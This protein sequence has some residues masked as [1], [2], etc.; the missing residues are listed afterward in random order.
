MAVSLRC[1]RRS[2]GRLRR[3]VR[4]SHRRPWREAAAAWQRLGCPYERALALAEG[5]AAAQLEALTVFD[6]L[7]ARPAA[8][9]V[10]RRLKEAGVRG[11]ARGVRPSTRA[12]PR[13]LTAR[14][15]EVLRLLCEGLRNAEIAS[16]LH[17]SVRTVDHHVAAVFA[18]L[19][20]DSRNEALL[21]AQRE[22][23]LQSGQAATPD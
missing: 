13:G 14:E 16:R 7:G 2:A 8:E 3:A 1:A 12:N 20:V 6:A 18:K 19:G 22:G 15:L 10:R 4:V 9:A 17:R 21:L 23:L 11:I 5:D